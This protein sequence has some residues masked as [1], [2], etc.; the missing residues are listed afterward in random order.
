MDRV[1]GAHGSQGTEEPCRVTNHYNILVPYVNDY[2]KWFGCCGIAARAFEW[3]AEN[4]SGDSIARAKE[5]KPCRSAVP[6]R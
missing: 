5:L 4:R 3:A 1:A 6:R 2:F